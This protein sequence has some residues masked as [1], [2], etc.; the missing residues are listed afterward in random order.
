MI[1]TLKLNVESSIPCTACR[2]CEH[3]CPK[4]IAIP[5]YFAL[6]NSAKRQKVNFSSQQVY[7]INISSKRGKAKD[8]VNCKQCEKACPQ[9]LP[10]TDYLKDVSKQFDAAPSFPTRK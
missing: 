1:Y 7:Y 6:Y 10:I 4:N 2:Y 8:C 3:G 9:H 5:D